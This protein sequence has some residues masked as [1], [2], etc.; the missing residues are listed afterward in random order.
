MNWP[1]RRRRTE[2]PIPPR[3]PAIQR[4]E[5]EQAKARLLELARRRRAAH[6]Y[7]GPIFGPLP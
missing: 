6:L 1:I 5:H 7:D 4:A 3:G 2:T